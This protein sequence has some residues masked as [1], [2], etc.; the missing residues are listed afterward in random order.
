MVNN[1]ECHSPYSHSHL[2]HRL[3]KLGVDPTPGKEKNYY[4]F[5]TILMLRKFVKQLV[6]L[7]YL[8]HI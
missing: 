1:G 7:Y 8:T 2:T 6:Q 3:G 4:A 5:V